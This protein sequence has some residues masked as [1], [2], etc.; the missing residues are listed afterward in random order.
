MGGGGTCTSDSIMG[1]E[2]DGSCGLLVGGGEAGVLLWL[3]D[4]R[5]G[6]RWFLWLTGGMR[7]S[8][9]LLWLTD[10]RRGSRCLL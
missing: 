4:S 10:G 5:R 9:C 1:G 8:R 6:G 7:R 3:T 2:A